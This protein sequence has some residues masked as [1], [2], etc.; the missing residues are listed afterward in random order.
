MSKPTATQIETAARSAG[1]NL[2]S[3][4][5]ARL[6]KGESVPLD[7]SKVQPAAAAGCSGIKLIDLGGGCALYFNPFPPGISVCCQTA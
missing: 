7:P 3:T 2:Q 1:L 6:E 5:V 4:D